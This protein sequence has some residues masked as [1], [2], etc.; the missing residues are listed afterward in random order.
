MKIVVTIQHPAHVH[1]YRHAIVHLERG[2]HEVHVF[3]REN[4]LAVPL[5]R[6]YDI[7]H[8]VLAGP[9]RSLLGLA[10][11]QFSYELRLLRRAR[12]IDPDVMT[13]IGGVAVSH[14]A[15]L[16]GARSVVFIDNEG[17]TSHRLMTPFADVVATPANHEADYGATHLRYDGFQELAYLHP[18]RF[19][20]APDR[21]LEHGVDPEERYFF[22]RFKTW[23]AL[24]DVGEAGLT[25]STK[26]ELVSMLDELGTV[27]I[28]SSEP[29][30]PDL[31]EHRSPVPPTLVHDLC[32]H[33][34]LYAG[35]SG[36]MATEAALLGT[37]AV[38]L[39]SFAADADSD[40]SNF[41]RLEAEYD[42]LRSTADER[43]A[44]DIVR[45]LATDPDAT[46]RWSRRRDRLLAE[47]V[48]VTPYVVD[49][50]TDGTETIP[51]R[52]RPSTPRQ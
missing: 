47:T 35:D 18:D 41:V 52:L 1:F 27:Y 31:R 42:L 2:G 7:D 40:M 9:Q 26:R 28:S 12:R 36:T 39:Q 43:E 24:H 11:V 44:I 8:E 32:Y 49:V 25:P 21:L 19:E 22:L 23:D 34:D 29:L 4:D 51:E 17:I 13:A 3:A 14:V 15:P 48:D 5:L 20:P 16:V 37:P 46:A 50:L 10:A 45:E 30:P 6:A 38:R 33:A